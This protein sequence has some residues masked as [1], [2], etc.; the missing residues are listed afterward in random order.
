MFLKRIMKILFKGIADF[1][2]DGGLMLAGSISYFSMMA[3]IPFCLLLVTIFG[4]ALEENRE[5]LAFFSKKLTGF[6]P[7]ITDGITKELEK[8]ISYR[9]IGLYTLILYCILSFEL[10]SAMEK[11]INI[12][13][14]IKTK[15]SFILSLILSFLLITVIIG[16]IMLSFIAT[17]IISMLHLYKA[18]FPNV[19][20]GYLVS[21]MISFAIP[22][23]LM[24]FTLTTLYI[25]LPKKK[26]KIS[27]ALS[28]ALFSAILFEIAKYLFTI[29]ISEVVQLGTIYGSLSAFVIFLLWIFYSTCIFLIGAEVVHNLESPKK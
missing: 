29:Y 23:I 22:L 14:K 10:F 13:F 20:I 4:A 11:A 2:K 18:Y 8:I 5:L 7:Q 15:R 3:L 16:F 28:G 24:I 27:H 12:I 25:F 21:F 19:E 6:F 9:G 26:V 17:S 1:Y